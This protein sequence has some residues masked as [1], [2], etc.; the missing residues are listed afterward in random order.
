MK[1]T[2][3][4][5]N[6]KKTKS[7]VYSALDVACYVI[8]YCN[9]NNLKISHFK[10]QK[11]LYF[12]QASSFK[13]FGKE[14]FYNDIEAWPSG[15]VVLDVYD[16]FFIYTGN[17]IPKTDRYMIYNK[18]TEFYDTIYFDENIFLP[19]DKRLIEDVI[20]L[21]KD[22]DAFELANIMHCQKPFRDAFN[23]GECTVITT[24]S[25][26]AYFTKQQEK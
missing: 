6:L 8:N 26:K 12:I 23:L 20:E 18:E 22:C 13:R 15:S 3:R 5:K 14:I 21:C 25:M 16:E 1:W 10:L 24:H 19:E 17:N 7:K 2:R 4:K 11:L 9:D